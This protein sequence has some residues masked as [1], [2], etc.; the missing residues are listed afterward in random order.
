MPGPAHILEMKVEIS[1]TS[2]QE[3]NVQSLFREMKSK[4]I[5]LG[6]KLIT[7]EKSLNDEFAKRSMTKNLLRQQLTSISEVKKELRF[8]HLDTH[9][10]ANKI[11]TTAQIEKY[12][13][14]RGYTSGDPCK[15]IPTG[16]DSA[17]WK[18]HNNCQ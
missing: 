14:L 8:V 15:N 7:L 11:L 6:E 5:P 4:A 17:L 18:K 12:N 3:L 9:L 10:S 2:E 1:L 13:K 16:H